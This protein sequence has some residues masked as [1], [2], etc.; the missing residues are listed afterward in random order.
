MDV[1]DFAA[2][3]VSYCFAFSG[4]VTSWVRTVEHNG[5]VGGVPDSA[6]LRGLACDVIY[7][8]SPPGDEADDWLAAHG[9]RRIR[10]GDH[11]HLM[12][13]DWKP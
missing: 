2:S 3:A 6:H 1:R 4:S 11:D 13:R 8:G 7:D 5:A 12:P 10:E 9:L